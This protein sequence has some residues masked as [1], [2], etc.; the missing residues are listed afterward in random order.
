MVKRATE[1]IL[2]S[3]S[4]RKPRLTIASRSSRVWILEVAWRLSARASSSFTMPLP[5]S[6]TRIIL[7]P[8]FSI[9]ISIRVAPESKLFSTSSFTTEAGLSTTSPAAIWFA[10]RAGSILIVIF[11]ATLLPFIEVLPSL[12]GTSMLVKLDYL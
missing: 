6:R 4:P 8:P 12:E 11:I 7:A 1:L 9:S 5:L 3:A 10:K 2:A